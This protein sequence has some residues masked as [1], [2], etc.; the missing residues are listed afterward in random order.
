MLN[1]YI[2]MSRRHSSRSTNWEKVRHQHNPISSHRW[3][4]TG[5]CSRDKRLFVCVW[6]CVSVCYICFCSVW[7]C[8]ARECVCAC[9]ECAVCISVRGG[10]RVLTLFESSHLEQSALA[11]AIRTEKCLVMICVTLKSRANSSDKSPRVTQTPVSAKK[12]A[13]KHYLHCLSAAGQLNS[14]ATLIN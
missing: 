14:N 2:L 3:V 9:N 5:G 1:T 6:V 12:R 11:T 7:T 8:D 10:M 4:K 13:Q